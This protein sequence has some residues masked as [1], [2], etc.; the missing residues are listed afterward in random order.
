MVKG[1]FFFYLYSNARINEYTKGPR[2]LSIFRENVEHQAA[3]LT[4]YQFKIINYAVR[5]K[6]QVHFNRSTC[7]KK[8]INLGFSLIR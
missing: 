4:E 6:L 7:A 3:E 2:Y 1:R 5:R 8:L